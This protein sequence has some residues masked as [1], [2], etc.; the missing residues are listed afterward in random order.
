MSHFRSIQKQ[1][2]TIRSVLKCLHGSFRHNT[3]EPFSQHTTTKTPHT[4]TQLRCVLSLHGSE[5]AFQLTGVVAW[6]RRAIFAAC[7]HKQAKTTNT[8]ECLKSAWIWKRSPSD[9]GSTGIILKSHF[10][11]RR[12]GKKK[13][14]R[15]RKKSFQSEKT[16]TTTLECLKSAW[17]GKWF[18]SWHDTEEPF[19]Q[20]KSKT[21]PKKSGVS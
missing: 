21:R 17:I 9:R 1:N 15:K 2:K 13:E 10:R 16:T 4:K 20:H 8:A 12:G 11:N 6:Y 18:P 7:T 19:S 5:N 3:E 14:K